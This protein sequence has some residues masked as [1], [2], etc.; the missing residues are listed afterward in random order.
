MLT[1]FGTMA[2]DTTRTPFRVEERIL[3]GA[4]TFAS[5][6]A[7]M[8][9]RTG[10]VAAIGED[11]PLANI[12][13]VRSKGVD[14]KG[15]VT[16]RGGK[17]FHYDSEFDYNL[18]SRTT[19]KTELNV[20]ADFDPVI[21]EEYVKSE[22]VYL[23]NNDPRQNMKILRHFE[24]PKLVVCDTIEYWIQT[25]RDDVVK[26]IG[27]TDGVVINDSEARLLCNEVNIAK[28][29][30][31]IMSFGPRFAIIKK[32]EHGA[33]LFTR[34]GEVFPAAAFFLDEISDPTGAGDSFAGGFLGHIARKDKIDFRTM[35]EAVIYG[36][37]MGSFAVE[38]FGVR[39]LLAITKDD[40]E[41][42]YEKYRNLVQF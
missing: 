17:C 14:T 16:V 33:V 20:I 9:A 6:S 29:A 28:C 39:R 2:L 40:V 8:F 19:L 1:V 37:V 3:G 11:M 22:Y 10:M 7:G 30:R 12:E 42:R 41:E 13:A 36:N 18:S 34:E 26:M 23:A 38:D 24:K 32:G 4:A 21:P 31:Q 27:K 15:I 5:L 25:A 35:K